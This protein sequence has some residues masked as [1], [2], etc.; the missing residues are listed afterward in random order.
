MNVS[1]GPPSMISYKNIFQTDIAPPQPGSSLDKLHQKWRT[2][3]K[4][5]GWKMRFMNDS[6]GDQWVSRMFGESWGMMNTWKGLYRGVLKADLLRYLLVLIEGGVYSD[7]DVSDPCPRSGV[8][9]KAQTRRHAETVID[10]AFAPD[11]TLGCQLCR[12]LRH[13]TNRRAELPLNP[14]GPPFSDHRRGD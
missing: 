5:D 4:V 6:L 11:R 14:L 2:F 1:L 3:N 8:T 13:L 12:I 9:G 7:M 10:S